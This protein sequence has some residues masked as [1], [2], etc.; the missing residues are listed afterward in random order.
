MK[1]HNPYRTS[2]TRSYQ[3]ND[4]PFCDSETLNKQRGMGGVTRQN[5]ASQNYT[6]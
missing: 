1:V 6:K 3:E 4:C 2:Y 5:R